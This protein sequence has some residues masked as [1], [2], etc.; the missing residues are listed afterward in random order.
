[1]LPGGSSQLLQTDCAPLEQRAREVVG[2]MQVVLIGQLLLR[3]GPLW[4]II[5]SIHHSVENFAYCY[6]YYEE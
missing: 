2:V 6:S 4:Y 5:I 1:M 3:D